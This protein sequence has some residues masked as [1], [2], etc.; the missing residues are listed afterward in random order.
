[1]TYW[2]PD[3][4]IEPTSY[5]DPLQPPTTPTV[6][7]IRHAERLRLQLRERYPDLPNPLP[8]FWSIGAD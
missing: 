4:D 1:M 6:D 8:S 5:R 7:E 3:L 2:N